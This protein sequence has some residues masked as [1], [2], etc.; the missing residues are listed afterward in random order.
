MKNMLKS[1]ERNIILANLKDFTATAQNQIVQD[2]R[3]DLILIST[4]YLG[5]DVDLLWLI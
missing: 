1:C 3:N 2:Q 4:V 5:F